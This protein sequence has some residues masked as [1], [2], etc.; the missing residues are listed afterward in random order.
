ME[1]PTSDHWKAALTAGWSANFR[2]RKF[3]EKPGLKD[4]GL[5]VEDIGLKSRKLGAE[6]SGSNISYNPEVFSPQPQFFS[7]QT[8]APKPDSGVFFL[9]RWWNFPT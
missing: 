8:L 9:N 3:L 2:L 1:L 4:P 6:E 5:R 7:P